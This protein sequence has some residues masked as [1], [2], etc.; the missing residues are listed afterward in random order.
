MI[1]TERL[2][3]R[4][5]RDADLDAYAAIL[6][7]PEVADWI[8][9]TLTREGTVERM[10]LSNASLAS[11]GCGRLAVVRRADLALIGHCGLLP[12]RDDIEL[13]PGL[14]VGW[15]L[16]RA[17]WGEG[18]AQEA[19][20]AAIADGLQR[21]GLREVTAF[22]TVGNVRSQNVMR[23]LG[24]RRMPDRDFDHPLFPPGHPLRRHLVFVA[25]PPL[26]SEA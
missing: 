5:W 18:Y 23:R 12:I 1:E 8:G 17:A 15:A 20:R 4:P 10:A 13:A 22:T 16:A 24:M 2:V 21:L 19:A 6:A 14:E 3:L 25:D 26:N 7:D 11:R 9:G